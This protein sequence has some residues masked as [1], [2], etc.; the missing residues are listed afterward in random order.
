MR[1]ASH[2]CRAELPAAHTVVV[3]LGILVSGRGSNLEAVLG[4]KIPG[5]EP[6]LVIS[7]R[8]GAPALQ[9]AERFGTPSQTLVR[10]DFADA[11]A[12]DAAI[13]RAL[14]AAGCDLAL[15]AGYDQLLAG[16]YFGTFAGQTINIHPSLLPAHGGRGMLGLAVHAAVLAAGEIETGVT[17]HEVTPELDAGP[18]LARARVPVSP[19]DDPARLA[20][21]VLEAEHRLLV[22]TLAALVGDRSF[23]MSRARMAGASAVQAGSHETH[24]RP[25]P[26]A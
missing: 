19:D 12:R 23:G 8:R 5:L 4:A 16:S 9:V 18:I 26:H 6:A 11:E 10:A 15:L 20:D 13:G 24:E 1:R 17:I 7:N 21:R 3:K 2:F 14:T 22:E 25:L